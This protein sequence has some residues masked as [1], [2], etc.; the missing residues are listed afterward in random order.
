[1]ADLSNR[2]LALL[3]VVAILTSI[4]STGFL[5]YKFSGSEGQF[6]GMATSNQSGET[7]FTIQQSLSIRFNNNLIPFGSG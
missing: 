4:G 2:A 5:L 7:N 6:V 3:L 1:M